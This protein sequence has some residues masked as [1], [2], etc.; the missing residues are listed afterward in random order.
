MQDSHSSHA[1]KFSVLLSQLMVLANILAQV[2]L[3]TPLGPQN[4]NAW[5]KWLF[6]IEFFNVFVMDVW[7]ITLS[8][9]VG[10]YFRA[11]TKKLSMKYAVKFREFKDRIY[12]NFRKTF[13]T[14]FSDKRSR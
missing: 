5:A 13:E 4:R 11:E 10:L 8:K 7:P 1:S 3:P 6:L 2:V 14:Q 9:V 12:S